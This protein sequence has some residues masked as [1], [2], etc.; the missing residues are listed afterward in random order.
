MR[1]SC[2]LLVAPGGE[3]LEEPW[4]WVATVVLVVECAELVVEGAG[5]TEVEVMPAPLVPLGW[6]PPAEVTLRL[7]ET[8]A[9]PPPLKGTQPPELSSRVITCARTLTK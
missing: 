7:T 9:R 2:F 4:P 1:Y 5:V 6:C 8:F 3:V